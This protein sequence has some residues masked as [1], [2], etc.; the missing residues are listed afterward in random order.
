M[1]KILL[2]LCLCVSIG[3]YAEKRI[4]FAYTNSNTVALPVEDGLTKVDYRYGGGFKVNNWNNMAGPWN[5]ATGGFVLAGANGY[6]QYGF[7]TS[8]TSFSV[9]HHI[10]ATT[11]TPEKIADLT[12]VTKDWTFHIAIKT[13]HTGAFEFTIQDKTGAQFTMDIT[14]KITNR[15]LGWNEIEISMDDFIKATNIDFT[16]CTFTSLETAGAKRDIWTIKGKDVTADGNIGWDDCYLTDNNSTSTGVNKV[17]ENSKISINGKYLNLTSAINEGLT[18][19]N[20]TGAIVLKTKENM[21]DVSG[22]KSGVYFAKSNGNT[23]KF[24]R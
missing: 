22:L 8:K 6:R 21:L 1:K 17:L 15:T 3:M 4:Y 19:Y 7:T 12:Q 24:V 18:V 2:F 14:E 23:F 5:P 13:N 11:T 10:E 9:I 20:S 16:Q